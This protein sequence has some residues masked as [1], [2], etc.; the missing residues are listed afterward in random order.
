MDWN[1]VRYPMNTHLGDIV[2]YAHHKGWPML[3]AVVVNQQHVDT[4]AMEESTLRG[5][6]EAAK[7][8]GHQVNDPEVFLRDQQEA[9]FAWAK[10]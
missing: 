6:V 2:A 3:S 7:W 10:S 8:L 1:A 5:F 4:G 9:V